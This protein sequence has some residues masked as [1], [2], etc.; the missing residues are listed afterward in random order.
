MSSK[1]RSWSRGAARSLVLL[2]LTLLGAACG[3]PWMV[4]RQATPIPFLGQPLAAEP[5]HFDGLVVGEKPEPVYLSEK[6]PGQ[7]QS[8]QTDKAEAGAAFMGELLQ[9][10]AG[11]NL[12]PAMPRLQ[13]FIV[14]ANIVYF[15]PGFY[16]GV[17]ARNAEMRM[18]LQILDARGTVLDEVHSQI[19]VAAHIGNPSSGGRMREGGALLGRIAARYLRYRLTGAL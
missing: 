2:S 17:A 12:Q 11:L 14:R 1:S 13:G 16:V 4:V 10:A 19:G 8:W 3:P 7:Q 15:E 9:G 6:D 18:V 5:L